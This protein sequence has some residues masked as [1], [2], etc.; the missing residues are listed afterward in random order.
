MKSW[1]LPTR[2]RL[3]IGVLLLLTLVCIS[4]LWKLASVTVL[5]KGDFIG[6]WSAVYLLHEGHN[7]Y[8]PAG[9]MEIQQT[10]I[11]SG[12]DFVVMAWN[13]PT[14]F[15]FILPLA[16]LP[17]IAAKA[18]WLIVNVAILLVIIFMLAHLYLPHGGRAFLGFCLIVILF[19]QAL[20]AIIMGQVTF[21]VLLGVVSSMMLI[22]KEQWFWAGA[23]LIL[24][25]VKPHMALLAVPYLLLYMSYRRK[26]RGWLG[27]LSAAA[28][29][30]I[31][32]FW[33]RPLWA[34]DF[35]SIFAIAPVNWAT[36]TIG[37]LLSFLRLTEAMRYMVVLLLPLAWVLAR[38]QTNVSVE[39][40]VALLT[41]LTVPTTFYGWSYDQSIL[42]IPIAQIFSWLLHPSH[43][44]MRIAVIAAMLVSILI[45]WIQRISSASEVYYFWIPLFWAV[46]Y[47]ICI[48]ANKASVSTKS[49]A[50]LA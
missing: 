7:P 35:M 17:F 6:Y 3:S 4:A 16:W 19:P 44:M 49:V 5:G 10:L 8:D 22:R 20:V 43:H 2:Q 29:C 36:P 40:A 11:H 38:Q 14:L 42:L 23:S 39:T 34:I 26:W 45:N 30:L 28:I 37:G 9:M 25:T 47:S 18:T 21:L 33:F 24:T 13:P 48:A 50:E 27:L 31:T 1:H 15:V 12:L 32:L 41:I 46:V